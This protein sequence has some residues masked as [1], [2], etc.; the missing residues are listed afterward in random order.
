VNTSSNPVKPSWADLRI[1]IQQQQELAAGPP[2]AGGNCR[3]ARETEIDR[4]YAASR[5][6]RTRV[7]D[8]A[9]RSGKSIVDDEDLDRNGGQTG[10]GSTR[11]SAM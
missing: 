2:G 3:S 9:F 4:V 5:M 11:G 7:S 1:I 8:P 10:P 6:P